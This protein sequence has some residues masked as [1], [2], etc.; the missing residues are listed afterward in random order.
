MASGRLVRRAR[1]SSAARRS[2]NPRRLSAPVN[3]SVMARWRSVGAGASVRRAWEG[4]GDA[5]PAGHDAERGQGAE[6]EPQ[7][8]RDL[9]HDLG[10]LGGHGQRRQG[11]GP[12]EEHGRGLA[13][14]GRGRLVAR[15]LGHP[16]AE[17]TPLKCPWK[18]VDLAPRARATR[19]WSVR[20]R[21]AWSRMSEQLAPMKAQVYLD[22][23]PAEYFDRFHERARTR[24]PD[25]VYE[26]VKI[27]T[28]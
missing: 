3:G 15:Q 1:A 27:A 7:P 23:R 4:R 13:M 25:P 28:S 8:R 14:R 6:G 20:A 18:P 9:A 2:S 5:P 26:L 19:R 11:H 16:G 21:V 22:P 24:D 12:P 10:H 17:A